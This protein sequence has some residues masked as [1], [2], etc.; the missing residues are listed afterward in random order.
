MINQYEVVWSAIA[1]DDLK[2]LIEYV[3]S[4]S[5]SDALRIFKNLKQKASSLHSFPKRGRIIPE[6]RDHVILQYRELIVPPWRIFYRISE[7]KVN[8]LSVMD[9]RQNIEDILLNRLI[10]ATI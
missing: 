4:D 6:L 9:S 10:R 2:S 1:E 3:A 5:P 7:N 8:I